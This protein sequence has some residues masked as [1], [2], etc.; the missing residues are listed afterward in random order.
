MNYEDVGNL[1]DADFKRLFAAPDPYFFL[2]IRAI[3]VIRG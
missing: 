3:R 2:I 1:K